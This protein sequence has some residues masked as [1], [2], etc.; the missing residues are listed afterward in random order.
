MIPIFVKKSL[1]VLFVLTFP[2]LLLSQNN[3]VTKKNISGKAK[4]YYEDYKE[5]KK[6]NEL[7]KALKA[8]EKCVA[9]EPTFID[10]Y[11]MMGTLQYGQSHYPEAE[12]AFTK[13]MSI[14]N[15]YEPLLYVTLGNLQVSQRKNKEAV[16]NYEAFLATN[17]QN[18]DLVFDVKWKLKNARFAAFAKNSYDHPVPFV[19]SPMS[20]AINSK[21]PEYLPS[22]TLDEKQLVFTRRMQQNEDFF[23]SKKIDNVW[24]PAVPITEINTLKS[25][26]AETISADG[27]LI[28]FAGC[29]RPDGFG[30]CDL[31]FSEFINGTW[32]K[33]ANMGATVNSKAWD[34][35]PSIT[36]D[37]NTI[38]F[39][40]SRP[41]SIGK[42]DIWK[43]Q[44]DSNGK[45]ML[46]TVLDST[47]NTLQHEFTPYIHF[48]N[49]SLY[50]TSSG[51]PCMG[52]LDL[53]VAYKKADDTFGT[54]QNL[55]YPINT[56]ADEANLI[57]ASDG[58]TAY[59]VTDRIYDKDRKSLANDKTG[60][61]TD[62]YTFEL[63][64]GVRAQAAVTYVRAKVYDA[65]TFKPILA[66]VE[67]RDL[68]SNQLVT[69]INTDRD[70]EFMTALP[71]GKMYSLNV[72]KAKYTFYSD[73]FELQATSELTQPFVLDIPLQPIVDV[74]NNN[75]STPSSGNTTTATTKPIVLKN[76]FFATASAVL[77]PES[78][79]EI[80]ALVLMLIQNP[81]L[82]I[83]LN[84]HT[85]NVGDDA[86]N[87]TLSENRAKAVFDALTK[88]GIDPKR[89]RYKGF[90]K[91][92]PIDSND[93]PSGRQNNR[94]TEFVVF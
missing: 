73:R 36:S 4:K 13:A 83:Q 72:N 66:K 92:Q 27:K 1:I 79:G 63:P 32:T 55:G 17:S 5:Q 50:F 76:I 28:V 84:G 18:K 26:G 42:E 24:Q 29:N 38:Y 54:P 22:F 49:Q 89:L 44:K 51:H 40:S 56:L 60:S 65:Q 30:D 69:T 58:K 19:V 59:F 14:S 16:L 94:R 12:A 77:K 87:L 37:G 3:Y 35:Q 68:A 7:E 80:Q 25:E 11:I 20:D 70:G 62:I 8:L 10:G 39:S 57:V 6:K 90:G 67:I 41:G 21:F 46:P 75:T 34:S 71:F 78:Q 45:W 88:Q 85:D 81:T 91:T 86:S 9:V 61:E 53:F 82:R 64:E 43:T 31:Y 74:P 23:I 33:P 52:G 15:T 2:F 47:I 48:D 93:S